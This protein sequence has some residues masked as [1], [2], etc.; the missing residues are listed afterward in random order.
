MLNTM[1]RKQF[2][3]KILLILFIAIAIFGIMPIQSH[4]ANVSCPFG[5]T[6][7]HDVNELGGTQKTAYNWYCVVYGG[8]LFQESKNGS[9]GTTEVLEFDVT[10]SNFSNLWNTCEN[11]YNVLS[12]FGKML[13][14][15]YLLLDI[16]EKSTADNLNAEHFVKCFIKGVIGIIVIDMGWDIVTAGIGFANDVF[17]ELMASDKSFSATGV[18]PYN[19]LHEVNSIAGLVYMARVFIPWLLMMGA[20]MI[21]SVICWARILDLVVRVIFAPI[22]MADMMQ[23]GTRGNGWKYFKKIVASALQ[24]AVILAIVK[25]YGIITSTVSSASGAGGWVVAIILA[26]VVISVSFKSQSIA[27]DIVGV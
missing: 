18:C 21:I 2:F 19:D 23:E 11:Y 13:V 7:G 22:G 26:F 5:C 25:S 4:A 10:S 14:V 8:Q 12:V 3:T 16:M 17:G 20:Q 24:G 15:I 27:S 9:L 6:G 1:S